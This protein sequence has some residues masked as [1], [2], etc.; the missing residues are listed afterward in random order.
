MDYG[1]GQDDLR[2]S[3]VLRKRALDLLKAGHDELVGAQSQLLEQPPNFKSILNLRMATE[4]FLK[5]TLVQEKDLSDKALRRFSHGLSDS[6]K[7]CAEATKWEVFNEIAELVS[8]Y[9]AIDSRYGPQT[10]SLQQVWEA[11][12]L[13]QGVAA[14]FT[15]RYTDR[16]IGA[17]LFGD[18]SIAGSGR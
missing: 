1:Y 9:P 13:T 8:I 11:A 2:A 14:T 4:I 17:E 15:R 18:G 12:K 10:C 7:A 5:A 6:A 3:G 16:N